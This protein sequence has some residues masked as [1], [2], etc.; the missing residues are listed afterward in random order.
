MGSVTIARAIARLEVA[1]R[2]V[3]SFA[4]GFGLC[5]VAR[6]NRVCVTVLGSVG[7]ANEAGEI[8]RVAVVLLQRS[9]G[10]VD[11]SFGGSTGIV[12]GPT[13]GRIVA[14]VDAHG[15]TLGGATDAGQAAAAG[16]ADLAIETR[17]V[18]SPA[19]GHVDLGVHADS[20]AVGSAAHT[21]EPAAAARANLAIGASYFAGTTIGGVD[22]GVDADFIAIGGA[23][24]ARQAAH[25]VE[26]NLP[27]CANRLAVAAVAHVGLGIY[28]EAVAFF[29]TTGT[30]DITCAG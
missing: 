7:G 12:A 4:G 1:S 24:H 23:T 22:V 14:G 29:H 10:A 3:A 11:A 30:F 15:A 27:V 5:C 6:H 18:A 26:T 21:S 13:V 16:R 17:V 19:M 8:E 2:S 20:A 25:A 28:A 9:A